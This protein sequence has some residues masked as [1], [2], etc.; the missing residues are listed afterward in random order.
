MLKPAEGLRANPVTAPA[1]VA[2][3]E[4]LVDARLEQNNRALQ[5]LVGQ[6]L[7]ANV[8]SR[9]A[10]GTFLVR[11]N[12][13]PARMELPAGTKPGDQLQ[14]ILASMTPRPTFQLGPGQADIA[15]VLLAEHEGGDVAPQL[16]ST[17]QGKGGAAA[18]L[19]N[20]AYSNQDAVTR[21]SPDAGAKAAALAASGLIYE[22][23]E[24]LTYSARPGAQSKAIVPFLGDVMGEAD[25]AP[26]T[27]KQL[28]AAL[29]QAEADMVAEAEAQPAPDADSAP[30][31]NTGAGA[32]GG[33]P[34]AGA[35]L[36]A[37]ALAAQITPAARLVTEG[38]DTSAPAS[39]SRAGQMINQVL[40]S[41]A[42]SGNA[43]IGR[44][45][46]VPTAALLP[47]Q[48]AAALHDTLGRSGV[49]YESHVRQWADGQRSLADLVREPQ[50]QGSLAERIVSI[51][52]GP[53]AP[54]A[55]ADNAQNLVQDAMPE[56][57]AAQVRPPAP[58]D[59][60]VAFPQLVNLQLNTLENN[61]VQW[62]GQIWPGQQ[63][64]W[65]VKQDPERDARGQQRPPQER[66]WQSAM[67]FQFAGL[68]Q[69]D[70]TIHLVG[71]AVHIQVSAGDAD[72]AA[73]LR[74]SVPQL[75]SALEAAGSP[76]QSFTVKSDGDD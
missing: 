48:V 29:L 3:V 14:M 19:A 51:T 20:L 1:P 50:A 10:D 6:K 16:L 32:A 75:A 40:Q 27:A 28:A 31:G 52:Q 76:L 17:A 74:N 15:A 54:A 70:A 68:G 56:A 7:P 5:Q 23:D 44:T 47:E 45:P 34:Q 9:F 42:G 58:G 41:A 11:V 49:F 4:A 66:G 36:S 39:L 57:A 30:T 63:M 62:H 53:A 26:A 35:V 60:G 61:S 67:R 59:T 38:K 22:P 43:I 2:G 71:D 55:A 69:I 18:A 64:E 21:Y 73:R 46:I 33:R 24:P 65:E 25:G 37:A 8:V 13:T 72:S 12:D